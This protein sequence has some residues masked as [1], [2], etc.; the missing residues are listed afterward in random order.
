MKRALVSLVRQRALALSS[1]S[2]KYLGC[3]HV[4][5]L[6]TSRPMST[7]LTRYAAQTAQRTPKLFTEIS[8]EQ[9]KQVFNVIYKI[10]MDHH[11]IQFDHHEEEKKQDA[12]TACMPI[13]KKIVE[14][15]DKDLHQWLSKLLVQLNITANDKQNLNEIFSTILFEIQNLKDRLT[16]QESKIES[17]ELRI[18]TLELKQQM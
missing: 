10:L 5:A 14:H 15:N 6:S 7:T 16:N 1:E 18:Q 9:Y 8:M 4:F 2:V 13:L 17:Q 11:L 3:S 12:F